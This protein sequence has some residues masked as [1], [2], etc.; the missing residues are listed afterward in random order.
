PV[1]LTL[2]NESGVVLEYG[3]TTGGTASLAT[4][5]SIN[6]P[7]LPLDSYLLINPIN[8]GLSL[9]YDVD[10]DNNLVTVTVLPSG[11]QAGLRTVN[12]QSTGGIFIY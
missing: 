9:D 6:Y 11:A 5:N 10:V 2:V 3:L 1:G 7:N 4:G 8:A 12:V